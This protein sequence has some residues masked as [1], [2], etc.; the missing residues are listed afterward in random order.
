MALD[1][2]EHAAAANPLPARGRRHRIEHIETVAAADISR[3]GRL[4]VIASMQPFHGLPDPA[5]IA[6]WQANV[7]EDRA[8][9]AWAY[10]SIARH[11][12]TLAFGSDWPVV[13]IDPLLG[14]HVAVNRTTLDGEPGLH[15]TR[16]ARRHRRPDQGHLQ[17]DA[18]AHW[19][20]R[21]RNDDLRRESRIPAFDRDELG[22]WSD[23]G[24]GTLTA[25][26]PADQGTCQGHQSSESQMPV[27]G[28]R[29][30]PITCPIAEGRYP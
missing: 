1:A 29:R 26:Q 24:N 21:S 17:S 9:R 15:R 11:K 5:Q 18:C 4:G 14:L 3:F 2:V 16:H 7:G 23:Q 13:P 28:K 30:G 12:G 20:K 6:V 27:H 8:S 19:R 25:G 22:S 10:G